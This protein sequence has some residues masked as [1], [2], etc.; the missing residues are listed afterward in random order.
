MSIATQVMENI[1]GLP[2]GGFSEEL[3]TPRSEGLGL[4]EQRQIPRDVPD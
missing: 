1:L 2:K 4:P 3:P